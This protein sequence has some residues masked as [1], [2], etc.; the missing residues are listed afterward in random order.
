MISRW[1]M[2][3]RHCEFKVRGHGK[4]F[5]RLLGVLVSVSSVLFAGVVSAPPA[6][7]TTC[8]LG[9]A[10]AIGDIG[11]G[12]GI[13]FLTPSSTGNSTGQFF[14]AAPNTWNGAAPDGT[15]KWC[16]ISTASFSVANGIGAGRTNS[17]TIISSC[18]STGTDNAARYI[19][20]TTIG[21]LTDWF[22]PSRDEMLALY[23]Q[24]AFLTGSYATN[25][26]NVDAARYLTSS[27]SSTFTSNAI[28]VYMEGSVAPGTAQDVSKGFRFSVRPV[29]MFT[30]TERSGSGSGSSSSQTASTGPDVI[31][32]IGR[33]PS[34]DCSRVSIPSLDWGGATGGWGSSWAEWAIPYSAGFVCTRTLYSVGAGAW[35]VRGG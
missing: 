31:Q 10:C 4:R 15:A 35:A 2:S 33:Q 7:A 19:S 13:V 22:L 26:V 20:G 1:G 24:R 3:S 12:G 32:Q 25:R 5:I 18:I 30:A 29:R 8:A 28:G 16:D 23:N 17:T 11:P 21:G 27:Q 6:S 34:D 14:E 9:G